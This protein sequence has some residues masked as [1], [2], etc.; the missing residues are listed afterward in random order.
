AAKTVHLKVKSSG[1]TR[2]ILAEKSGRFREDLGHGNF[3]IS[4]GDMVWRV[5]KDGKATRDRAAATRDPVALVLADAVDTKPDLS[6]LKP[7]ETVKRGDAEYLVYRTKIDPT[8]GIELEA[9]VDAGTKTLHSMT[10]TAR[11]TGLEKTMAELLVAAVD[12]DLPEEKFLV[13]NS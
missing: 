3:R 1:A 11:L 13:L 7:A 12:V 10:L 4:D 2:E 6:K 5:D 9:L 8:N